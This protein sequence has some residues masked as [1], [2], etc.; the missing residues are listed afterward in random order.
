MLENMKLPQRPN[1]CGMHLLWEQLE[2]GDRA[3]LEPI[4]RD[5]AWSHQHLTNELQRLGFK[6]TYG[7]VKNHRLNMCSCWK[8]QEGLGD[9]R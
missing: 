1:N 5:K 9:P 6:I 8:Y 7:A 2:P 3:I 4:I